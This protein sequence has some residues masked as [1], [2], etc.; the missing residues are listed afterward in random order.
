MPELPKPKR[1][2]IWNARYYIKEVCG[3]E[4]VYNV[5]PAF[6][7][8][9]CSDELHFEG[10]LNIP[11]SYTNKERNRKIE[12]IPCEFWKDWG[13]DA[14]GLGGV[15]SGSTVRLPNNYDHDA[16]YYRNLTIA[17]ADIDAWLSTSQNPQVRV[18]AVSEKTYKERV[19]KALSINESYS[20]GEDREWA[21]A[22][23]F[24][25]ESVDEMRKL[26]APPEWQEKG[27]RSNKTSRN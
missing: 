20:R 21:K 11:A 23:G 1:V 7:D 14:F 24:S 3:L 15:L 26:H 19:E 4:N 9:L 12:R 25:V 16:P 5:N 8:A 13:Y 2:D 6:F 17:T 22:R 10:E 27:R 18:I